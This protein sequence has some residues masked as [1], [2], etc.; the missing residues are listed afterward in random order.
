MNAPYAKEW[1]H[2][3]QILRYGF[4]ETSPATADIW[5]EDMATV[6][7]TWQP[8]KPLLVLMDVRLQGTFVSAQALIRARQVSAVRPDLP[9]RTAV[10]IA[11][12]IASQVI[13][14]LIR[15]GLAGKVRQ[16]QIFA[17]ES[18]AI[19]WLLEG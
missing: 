5:F 3:G 13:S 11:S 2:D 1:I 9:G 8:D 7:R 4:H 16:R 19:S 10:L 18:R 14:S 17:D 12:P 6:F 15:T